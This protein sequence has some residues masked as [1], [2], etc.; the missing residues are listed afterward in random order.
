V[1]GAPITSYTVTSTPLQGGATVTQVCPSSPC[2]VTGLQPGTT[3]SETVQATNSSGTSSPS[4]ATNVAIPNVPGA[5]TSVA[6]T[7]STTTTGQASVSFTPPQNNGGAAITGYTVTATPT[8]GDTAITKSCTSSPCTLTGLASA[9][10]YAVTVSAVNQE[11]SSKPSTGASVTMPTVPGAPTG[12]SVNAGSSTGGQA[13]VSF[14]PPSSNGGAPITG[15]TIKATPSGGGAAVTQSCISSPCM[16]IGL[17]NATTYTFAVSAVNRIGAG[18]PGSAT[19]TVAVVRTPVITSTG[20]PVTTG[21]TGVTIKGTGFPGNTITVLLDGTAVGTTVVTSDGTWTFELPGSVT[22]GTYEITAVAAQNGNTSVVSNPATL[23]VLSTLQT[24]VFGS[25]PPKN[26][27]DGSGTFTITEPTPNTTLQCSLDGSSYETCQS[28]Y[29]VSGLTDGTHTATVRAVDP[30]GQLSATNSYTWLVDDGIA[31]SS[32]NIVTIMVSPKATA[33]KR[34]LEVACATNPSTTLRRCVVQA[35]YKGKIVATATRV[36]H[37]HLTYATAQIKPN[38]RGRLLLRRSGHRGFKLSI[39]ASI[40][41]RN[42]SVHTARII[43]QE[44]RA[45]APSLLNLHFAKNS[46][47]IS[48]KAQASIRKAV[49]KMRNVRVIECH[50]ATYRTSRH[51]HRNVLATGRAKALCKYMRHLGIKVKGTYVSSTRLTG[52][53]A[54]KIKARS[55]QSLIATASVTYYDLPHAK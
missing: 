2:T 42:N 51:S 38:K 28:S 55:K 43:T 32:D 44:Y 30:S 54:R 11:G 53:A 33:S 21:T 22:T 6:V 8:G 4:G 39:R 9:T 31:S 26:S 15:Y 20:G 3:Y 27:P 48:R 52:P 34:G 1:P 14:S 37:R 10:T 12:V 47:K 49:A 18:A 45:F 7:P 50:V 29:G 24:P 17:T 13:L 16:V 35:Y 25:T 23:T 40:Q 19:G 5:P 36:I 46:A 41:T